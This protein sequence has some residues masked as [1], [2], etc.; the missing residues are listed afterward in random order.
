VQERGALEV[1]FQASLAERTDRTT[2]LLRHLLADLP[3]EGVSAGEVDAIR[4]E[5]DYP[6]FVPVAL[7]VNGRTGY[8]GEFEMVDLLVP[9]EHSVFDR[10]RLDRYV[11]TLSEDE[12]ADVRDELDWLQMARYEAWFRECWAAV[13][14]TRPAVR[15]LISIHDSSWVMDLDTGDKLRED[16]CGVEAWAG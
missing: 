9:G 7:A 10:G 13:R 16:A 4:F 14:G 12:Q 3:F 6:S 15:G 11:E 2:D 1:S 8:V 5:Y